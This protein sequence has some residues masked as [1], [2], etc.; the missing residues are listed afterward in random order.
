[1]EVWVTEAQTEDLKISLRIRNVLHHE[2]TDYQE[3]TVVDT[4]AYGRMLLLDTFIQ[5]TERDEF[6]YHEMISHV[7]LFTHPNPRRVAVVGGGDGGTVREVLRHATVEEVVLAEIDERVIEASRRFLP[8]LSSGLDDPRTRIDIGDGKAHVRNNPDSYDVIIV[9]STDPIKAAEGLYSAEFYR[10]AYRALR[11]GG[12]LV[13]QTQSPIFEKD[14]IRRATA[15]MRQSFP[16]VRLYLA[17]VPTYPAGLWSFT[18]GSKG[19][20][21]LRPRPFNGAF[22]TRYY[23]DEVH[24][25]AFALPPFVQELV[26]G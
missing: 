1:M 6:I 20:D 23:T 17:T 10:D 12:V 11:D 18:L 7:P 25:A 22:P 13:V 3:L 21:P 4:V 15:N 9:D 19:P 24:R 26:Q 8:S 16:L 5:T 14:L 2:R